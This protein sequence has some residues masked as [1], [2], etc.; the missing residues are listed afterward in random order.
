MEGAWLVGLAGG[1]GPF[2][3]EVKQRY[4]HFEGRLMRD[5]QVADLRDAQID[6]TRIRFSAPGGDGQLEIFTG[7]VQDGRITGELRAG[8]AAAVVRWS[9]TRVP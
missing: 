5:A 4:Q 9:A 8:S 3:L 7:T 6:G 1:G 2:R